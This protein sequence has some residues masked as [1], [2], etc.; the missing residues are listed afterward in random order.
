MPSLRASIRKWKSNA[1]HRSPSSPVPSRPEAIRRLLAKGIWE[2][3]I[4][5]V[6]SGQPIYLQNGSEPI[7]ER[8][9]SL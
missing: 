2:A 8:Q 6:L 9:G 1:K 5:L 7:H 4:A 3:E